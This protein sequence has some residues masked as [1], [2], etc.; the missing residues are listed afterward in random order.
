M[1][2][3]GRQRQQVWGQKHH[4]NAVYVPVASVHAEEGL[5]GATI[6]AVVVKLAASRH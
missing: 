3:V 6:L 5:R 4:W 2:R 1:K